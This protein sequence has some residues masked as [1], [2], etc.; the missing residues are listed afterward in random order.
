LLVCALRYDPSVPGER[1]CYDDKAHPRD[2]IT[3]DDGTWQY[4][5]T[6]P[7]D[8]WATT[9]LSAADWASLVAASAP[10]PGPHSEGYGRLE[11]CE[12]LGAACLGL[13]KSMAQASKVWVRKAFSVPSSD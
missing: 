3:G 9:A 1:S 2:L 13:P 10:S 11:H 7:P 12:R 4:S 5:S 6:L 8:G